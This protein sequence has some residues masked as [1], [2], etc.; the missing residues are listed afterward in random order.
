LSIGIKDRA[1]LDEIIGTIIE[2]KESMYILVEPTFLFHDRRI[3]Q[4]GTRSRSF[5]H[6]VILSFS[7]HRVVGSNPAEI[8]KL[9]KDSSIEKEALNWFGRK[10]DKLIKM[11]MY[12]NLEDDNYYQYLECILRWPQQALINSFYALG[13]MPRY[14]N[15]VVASNKDDWP[16]LYSDFFKTDIS[17]INKFIKLRK[18]YRDFVKKQTSNNLEGYK[19]L[20][21]NIESYQPAALLFLQ[22]TYHVLKKY[23][24][25]A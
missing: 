15:G 17:E 13:E 11:S 5:L 20:L 7:Q 2:I 1:C 18:I 12:K 4:E 14:N 9:P 19:F 24:N 25:S 21:T 23:L 22:K 3:P 10:F 16:S 6:Y 8:I